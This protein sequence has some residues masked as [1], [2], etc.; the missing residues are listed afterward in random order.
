[1]FHKNLKYTLIA[2]TVLGAT[3]CNQRT[4]IINPEDRQSSQIPS[5]NRPVQESV[6]KEEILIKKNPT[7]GDKVAVPENNPSLGTPISRE[8]DHNRNLDGDIDKKD[9][10]SEIVHN[11]IMQRMPFPVGEYSRLR[12]RGRSTVTGTIYLEN[13]NSGEKIVGKKVK[14][15]LNP[16]T[17]YSNQWYQEDY[18]GGYKLSKIDKRIYNYMKLEYSNV[19]GKFTFSGIPRGDYYLVGS[20]A[21]TEACGFSKKN[22]KVRLVQRISVGSGVTRVDLRKNVP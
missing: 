11:T 4:I 18:L 1:M 19:D 8:D 5:V 7:L 13:S 12:K 9:M 22:K 2:L 21:C 3:G 10:E 6:I 17:S 16:V 14:L 20:V 15:W